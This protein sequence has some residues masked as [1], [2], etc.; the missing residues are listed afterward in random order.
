VTVTSVKSNRPRQ[1]TAGAPALTVWIYD[2]ALGAAAGSVRLRNLRERGALQIHEAI[3]VSWMPGVHQ[4][5]IGHLRHETSAGAARAS[6]LGGLV[7]LMFRAPATAVSAGPDLAELA[8]RLHGTGIDQLFL[9]EMRAQLH[10]ESSALLVLSGDVDL[11]IVRPVVERGLAR[12]DAV[13]MHAQLQHDA[14]AVLRDAVRD[15]QGQSGGA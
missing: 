14:P 15:L 3:T 6:V 4:P 10:P 8:L 5:R 7:D 11:D 12:G 2:T 13:L 9:E 1:P